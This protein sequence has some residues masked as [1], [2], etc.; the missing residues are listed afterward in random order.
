LP[1]LGG[2]TIEMT[3]PAFSCTSRSINTGKG[4]PRAEPAG[5]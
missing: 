3:R 1:S 5:R 2:P 4:Q